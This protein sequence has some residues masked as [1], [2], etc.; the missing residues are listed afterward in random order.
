MH[1]TRISVLPCFAKARLYLL[2]FLLGAIYLTG[3]ATPVAKPV[4][5]S[6]IEYRTAFDMGSATL[7]MKT[8]RVD[9]CRQINIGII[10]QKEVKVPFAENTRNHLLTGDIQDQGLEHLKALKQEAQAQGTQAYAGA[11]TAAFRQ[12]DNAPLF[13]KE[14]K[15][16]TGITIK[17]ISQDEEAVLGYKAAMAN[18]KDPSRNVVVWDIGGNSMQIVMRG[19]DQKYIVY[20]GHMASISFKNSILEKIQRQPAGV[21]S[22][23]NPIGRQNLAAALEMAMNAAADVPDEIQRYI[24]Q[25]GT[26]IIGIGGVH[27]QSIQKQLRKAATYR[28]DDLINV[29]NDRLDLTDRQI[30]GHYADTDVSNLIL[31]LGYMKKLEIAEVHLADVNLT[32]GILTDQAFW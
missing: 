26:N 25:A 6:C 8:A 31:V 28:R 19:K 2:A 32:D 1:K 13:L 22:S 30:G 15:D 9:K 24:R 4:K 10:G 20:C 7:K 12:A 18:A 14:I 16:K 5:Q 27:N 23:P 21:H 3:C 11:A 29:L 17:L